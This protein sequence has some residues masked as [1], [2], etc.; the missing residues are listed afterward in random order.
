MYNNNILRLFLLFFSVGN[1][2]GMSSSSLLDALQTNKPVHVVTLTRNQS[3]GGFYLPISMLDAVTVFSIANQ[4]LGEKKE[5]FSAYI[6]KAL[7]FEK[8][9]LQNGASLKENRNLKISENMRIKFNESDYWK[10]ESLNPI[11]EYILELIKNG[12]SVVFQAEANIEGIGK[13][14][15]NCIQNVNS[16][17]SGKIKG[18]RLKSLLDDSNGIS[19]NI[20]YKGTVSYFIAKSV[21][22]HEQ[23]VDFD[24]ILESASKEVDFEDLFTVEY[25]KLFG[26]DS[27][28]NTELRKKYYRDIYDKLKQYINKKKNSQ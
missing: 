20:I 3:E 15:L 10:D 12:Q 2:E 14:R 28:E 18:K 4:F 22:S 17:I 24:R 6:E 13:R 11:K 8:N 21:I 7:L 9:V 26:S 27:S 5:L 25:T 1:L 23:K 19:D 16:I